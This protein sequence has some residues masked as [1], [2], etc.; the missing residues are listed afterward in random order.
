[1]NRLLRRVELAVRQLDLGIP[2][3]QIKK[4]FLKSINAALREVGGS[5]L[6]DLDEPGPL[7]RAA[8][9]LER[10]I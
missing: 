5:Q 10:A 2:D 4:N 1:M 8:L 9:I 6:R 3:L 7:L